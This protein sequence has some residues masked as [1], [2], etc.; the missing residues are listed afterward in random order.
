MAE[1]LHGDAQRRRAS[2]RPWPAALRESAVIALAVVALVLLVA[3]VSYDP[4]RS[5]LLLQRAVDGDAQPRRRRSAPW[6]ADVLYFLFG[7]PGL[8]AAGDAGR[9]R[10]GGCTRRARTEQRG[11]GLNTAVRGRGLRAAAGRQL[12]ACA[13]CTGSRGCCVRGAPGGSSASRSAAALQAGLSSSAPRCCC[14][15][16]GWRAPSLAFGV[17]WFAVMDRL[18]AWPGRRCGWL[19]TRARSRAKRCRRGARAARAAPRG[20][21]RR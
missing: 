9:Q 13:R 17:S 4:R 15:P 21:R 5:G 7:R 18:G 10:P 2:R 12:R 16:P 19:R 20:G 8:P 14:W 1:S 3:L 6:L 11:R